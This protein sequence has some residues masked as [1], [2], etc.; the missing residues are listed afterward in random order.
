M[1]ALS[2]PQN[3]SAE[4]DILSLPNELL[5]RILDE[6]PVLDLVRCRTVGTFVY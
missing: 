6:V 5:V 4:M 1:A 2:L 3:I